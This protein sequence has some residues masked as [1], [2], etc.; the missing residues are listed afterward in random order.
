MTYSIIS[1]I[2]FYKKFET[3]IEDAKAVL[4][5]KGLKVPFSA[6]PVLSGLLTLVKA[7]QSAEATFLLNAHYGRDLEAVKEVIAS[8]YEEWGKHIKW[9]GLRHSSWYAEKEEDIEDLL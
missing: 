9:D 4:E 1:A 7:E 5:E 2:R 6:D 8:F 3:T